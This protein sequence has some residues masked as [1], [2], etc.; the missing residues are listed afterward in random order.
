MRLSLQVCLLHPPSTNHRAAVTR[1]L[2]PSFSCASFCQNQ[3][4]YW[5]LQ[6]LWWE[7]GTCHTWSHECWN[8]TGWM[9]IS[10]GRRSWHQTKVK[11]HQAQCRTKTLFWLQSFT[12]A[13][14]E[15]CLINTTT[16]LKCFPSLIIWSYVSWWIRGR[17]P[18]HSVSSLNP[19]Q[20]ISN[21]RNSSGS[22]M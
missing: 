4:H 3:N 19:S 10:V 9:F 21:I 2:R 22:N 7:V 18:Q 5:S 11:T 17:H 1:T 20:L 13:G 16:E 8:W 15:T 12:L 6:L 14:C